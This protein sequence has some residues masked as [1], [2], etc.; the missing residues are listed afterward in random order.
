VSSITSADLSRY[1]DFMHLWTR[2]NKGFRSFSGLESNTIHRWL[3]D[4]D[5]GEFSP[6]TI[7]KIM[8][9][10]G[11]GDGAAVEALDAGCGYGGTMFALHAA[12]GGRWHGLTISPRQFAVGRKLARQQNLCGAVTFARGSYDEAQ[13]LTYNLIYGIESLI[14]SVD[15]A[16]TIGNLVRA[17]RPGGT[18]VII[19]DM[20]ADGSPQKWA[21]HLERFKTL[22]R[23][24]VVPSAQQWSAHLDAAGCEVVEMRDL[25][26]LMRP[27][28]AP[29][30]AQAIEEVGARRRW[31]DR[32]GLRSI[33]EAETGGLL[34]ED[35]LREGALVYKLI[36]AQKRP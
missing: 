1:Y 32:L 21:S 16:R 6:I 26:P 24:P 13:A 8:L 7:H 20:Q 33:G 25:S 31:R 17:L 12:L 5:S 22:W 9:S 2:F 3:T 23:C 18:F 30:I 11:I 34:L 10:L 15:P 28:S 4:T 29:E 19:D 36:R 35:M 14:H 27:R